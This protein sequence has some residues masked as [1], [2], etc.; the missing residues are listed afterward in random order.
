M[1][2][3]GLFDEETGKEG[4]GWHRQAFRPT[5]EDFLEA[6]YQALEAEREPDQ[7]WWI[8]DSHPSDI[9]VAVKEKSRR[10][11]QEFRSLVEFAAL[12]RAEDRWSLMYQ[13]LWRL[14]HG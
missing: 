10:A 11:N 7:I 14:T 8:E 3:S 9:A 13:I 4:E 12:N 6:A 1:H 5:V 2:Q